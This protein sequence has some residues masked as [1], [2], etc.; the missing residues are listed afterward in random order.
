MFF[1]QGRIKNWQRCHKAYEYR[2]I[3]GL[4]KKKQEIPMLRGTIIHECLNML[5]TRKPVEPVIE[6][7]AKQYAQLFREEQEEYGD[8]PAEVARIVANYRAKY[9]NDGLT[10][11]KGPDGNKFEIELVADLAPGIEF[12]GHLDKL[13]VDSEG[14]LWI[15]AHKTHKLIPDEDARFSDLQTALYVILLPRAGGGES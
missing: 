10:Y 6:K 13:P 11:T 8:V 5:A 15:M 9:K 7:Y 14:R 1:S 2:Y 4:A 12:H 3:Q